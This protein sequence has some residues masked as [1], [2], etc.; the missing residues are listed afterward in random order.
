MDIGPKTL[1]VTVRP[2]EE[3]EQILAKFQASCVPRNWGV[4]ILT[5]VKRVNSTDD[6]VSISVRGDTALWAGIGKGYI[7]ALC[8]SLSA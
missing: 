8:D 4:E 5:E 6:W 1:H 2:P 3:A 7:L